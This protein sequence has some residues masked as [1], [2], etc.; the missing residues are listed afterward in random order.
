MDYNCT[1]CN[2]LWNYPV[3]KCIFCDG[4]VVEIFEMKYVIIGSTEVF[5]PSVDHEKVPYFVY[6]L[7]SERGNRKII[8]SYDEHPIGDIINLE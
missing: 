4:V 7:E 5:V 1:N 2:K 8:K 6:L 3:K